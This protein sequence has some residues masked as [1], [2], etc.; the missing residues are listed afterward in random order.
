MDPSSLAAN[1][2]IQ[3]IIIEHKPKLGALL[4]ILHAVQDEF[5]FI[6]PNAITLIAQA[7]N[8]TAAEI[9]GVISFYRHFHT[10]KP[11]AHRVE[12]CRAEACQARGGRALE[13]H[14]KKSLNVDYHQTTTD[15]NITL[16]PVYCLGNCACGPNIRIGNDVIAAVSP[17]KFDLTV[18]KL[19]TN[20]LSFQ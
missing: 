2:K 3:S 7:M 13:A 4:P 10:E 14:A 16:D 18:E 11:G 15:R 19:T 9:H 8:Q 20:T 1:E 5:N 12:I 6:P 17:A